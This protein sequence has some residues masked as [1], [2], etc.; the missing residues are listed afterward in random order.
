M[1]KFQ[2]KLSKNKQIFGEALMGE[3][4]IDYMNAPAKFEDPNMPSEKLLEKQLRVEINLLKMEDP[5]KAQEYEEFLFKRN[6][7]D[8]AI[9]T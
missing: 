9:A 6:E 5:E 3:E 1:D 4:G 7:Y 8:D 2:E